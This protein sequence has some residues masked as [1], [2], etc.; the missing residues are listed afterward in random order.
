MIRWSIIKEFSLSNFG[1][2]IP[3]QYCL[4]NC[5][6]YFPRINAQYLESPEKLHLFFPDSLHKIKSHIFQNICKC[7]IHIFRPFK[8]NNTCELCDNI[9][10]KYKIGIIMENKI[11]VLHEEVIDLFHRIKKIQ[12]RKISFHL[13]HVRILG[14]MECVKI[15]KVFFHDNAPKKI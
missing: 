13:A 10:N 3:N 2:K 4:F 7:L 8:Y 14:S 12:N 11:F 6:Y 1:I 9:Q 15:R 5:C